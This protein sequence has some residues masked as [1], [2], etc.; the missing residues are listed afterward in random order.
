MST[1][2]GEAN[3][4]HVYA[5]RPRARLATRSAGP[6]R[7]LPRNSP[8]PAAHGAAPSLDLRSGFTPV[9][10]QGQLGSCTAFAG[11]GAFGFCVLKQGLG[12]YVGSPL[13]LYYDERKDQG[14]TAHD[15][16]ASIREIMKALANYGLAPE[17][18]WPYD[19]MQF[20]TAPPAQAISDALQPRPRPTW[21]W[22]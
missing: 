2:K 4:T 19:I 22:P 15:T 14:D 8:A 1:A 13:Q 9:R 5:P 20:T 21:P 7:L 17:S 18:D 10:D 3:G 16:G 11:D 6:A 12:T